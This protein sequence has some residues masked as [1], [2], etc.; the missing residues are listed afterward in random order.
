MM[1]LINASNRLRA[2]TEVWATDSGFPEGP[3][4][5]SS[6]S[7][8][9]HSSEEVFAADEEVIAPSTSFKE[10]NEKEVEKQQDDISKTEN[11]TE[12]RV[13]SRLRS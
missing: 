2:T 3:A 9:D 12:S 4:P 6:T 7:H 1:I 10:K 13:L 11:K 8:E 5:Q